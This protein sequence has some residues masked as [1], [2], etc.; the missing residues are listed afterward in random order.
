MAVLVKKNWRFFK[1]RL[2]KRM[3]MLATTAP[4][5]EEIHMPRWLAGCH[6][7]ASLEEVTLKR[8]RCHAVLMLHGGIMM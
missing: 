7:V 1:A 2:R 6:E 8:F 4:D 3:V 5:W